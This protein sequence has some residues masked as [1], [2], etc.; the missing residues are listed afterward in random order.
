MN[1]TLGTGLWTTHGTVIFVAPGDNYRHC[2]A[3]EAFATEEFGP[4]EQSQFLSAEPDGLDLAFS[5]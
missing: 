2:V 4:M 5:F 1:S 3:Y